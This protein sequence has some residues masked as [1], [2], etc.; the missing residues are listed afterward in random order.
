VPGTGSKP[1]QKS[2]LPEI[3][4]E[5]GVVLSPGV[6]DDER[7]ELASLKTAPLRGGA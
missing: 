2:T 6:G 5:N 7:A 4:L 3:T 1:K